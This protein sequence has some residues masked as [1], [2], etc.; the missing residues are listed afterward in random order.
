MLTCTQGVQGL[1]A[2]DMRSQVWQSLPAQTCIVAQGDHQYGHLWL[3]Q[4][5]SGGIANGGGAYI[6]AEGD[7]YR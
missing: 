6:D 7:L 4:Y 2:D 3:V 1:A 5:S